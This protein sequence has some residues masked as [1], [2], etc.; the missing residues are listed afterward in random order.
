MKR[1]ISIQFLVGLVGWLSFFVWVNNAEDP[2]RYY[3]WAVTYGTIAPLGV[4][5]KVDSYFCLNFP[6]L[7]S[8]A[9]HI[10]HCWLPIFTG[11]PD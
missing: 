6:V 10:I 8:K 9:Y 2:Y 11:N 3:D 4:S 7:P 1:D 5:Q